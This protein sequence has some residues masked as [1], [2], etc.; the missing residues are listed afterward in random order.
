M[1]YYMPNPAFGGLGFVLVGLIFY[2]LL[3]VR[4]DLFGFILVVYICSDFTFGNNQG[5]LWNLMAF[6][7]SA[8]YLLAGP[9]RERFPQSDRLMMILLGIFILWNVLGWVV[10]NPMPMIPELQG[11]AEFFGFIL[12]FYLAS[13]VPITKE[14]VRLFLVVTTVLIFYQL[15]VMLNQR[16]PLIRWNTPLLGSYTAM[17]SILSQPVLPSLGTFLHAELGSEY[18]A[19]QVSLLV[20]LLSSSLTQRE[21]HCGSNRIVAMIMAC[22]FFMILTDNR[23]GIVLF[24]LAIIAYLLVLPMR[25]FTSIDRVGRQFRLVMAAALLIPMIG[26]YVGLSGLEHRFQSLSG[27]KVS[28]GRIVSGKDINRGATESHALHRIGGS[29][30]FIGYGSGIP[31]SNVWALLGHDPDKY[32]VPAA[33]HSLY[34][35]LPELYGWI[36]SLAFVTMIVVTLARSARVSLRYRKRKSVLIVLSVGFTMFWG[37]FLTNEYKISMMRIPNYEMLFWIWLGLSNS[38]IKTIRYEQRG[39]SAGAQSPGETAGL[40]KQEVARVT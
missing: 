17:G 38:V 4:R 7:I 21:L 22:L 32:G 28:I 40:T 24:V 29:S 26:A 9:R 6:G 39:G 18:G 35:S 27:E 12:M 5:G 10:R 16:Y 11:I 33:F 30:W 31:R 20:P 14:R 25:L 8:A 2:Y 15:L 23:S 19:L 36:G 34:F 13:N 3:F 37:V 1:K